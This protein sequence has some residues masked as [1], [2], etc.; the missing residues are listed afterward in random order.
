MPSFEFEFAFV[1]L[2]NREKRW[3]KTIYIMTTC[4]VGI[5]IL[6]GVKIAIMLVFMAIHAI[7]RAGYALD[8]CPHSCQQGMIHGLQRRNT[9]DRTL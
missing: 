1:M 2:L 8:R 7:F 9:A 5:F 3:S 6:F 4:T